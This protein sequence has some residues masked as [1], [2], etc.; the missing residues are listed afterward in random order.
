MYVSAFHACLNILEICH[1]FH[2]LHVNDIVWEAITLK[3]CDQFLEVLLIYNSKVNL[4]RISYISSMLYMN[5]KLKIIAK[6]I[7]EDCKVLFR[8]FQHKCLDN[9]CVSELLFMWFQVNH[10]IMTVNFS[11]SADHTHPFSSY[12]DL[13]SCEDVCVRNKFGKWAVRCQIV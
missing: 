8:V 12:R 2:S 4:I 1:I 7:V 6:K 3:D 13:F 11:T 9:K 10:I 5:I